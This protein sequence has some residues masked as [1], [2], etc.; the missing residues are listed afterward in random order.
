MLQ[1]SYILYITGL[2]YM[3]YDTM[4]LVEKPRTNDAHPGRG[5]ST[6]TIRKWV[7]MGH[8]PTLTGAKRREW[9]AMGRLLMVIVDHSR[10]FPTFSTSK[11][12]SIE[13]SSVCL[14]LLVTFWAGYPLFQVIIPTMWGQ[15]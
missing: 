14:C 7:K 15:R 10:N 3:G 11:N 13:P 2:L 5:R 1:A 4:I 12:L 8:L 9:M 6:P